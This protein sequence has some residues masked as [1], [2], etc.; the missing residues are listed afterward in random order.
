M[1]IH[2]CAV[3]GAKKSLLHIQ[4][5]IE[6]Y[7]ACDVKQHKLTDDP[8]AAELIVLVGDVA[9]LREARASRLLRQYPDKAMV[10]SE[11]DAVIP[12]GSGLYGS[13][14]KAR[15]FDLR[16]TRSFVYLSSY[17]TARNPRVELLPDTPKTL[18]FSFRGKRNCRVRSRLMNYDFRRDDVEVLDATNYNH[19]GAGRL[20]R[21]DAQREYVETVA[22]SHFA[23][24]P[25]GAG[26]GSIRLFEVMQM[27]VAPVLLADGYELPKGPNWS[28]FLLQVPER[29]YH[30]L[31]E[32]LTAH[33]DESR[34]RGR[35]ARAAWEQH[36]APGKAF[37]AMIDQL[38]AIR[39][40]RR[41]PQRLFMLLWP[42]IQLRA[43]AR[44]FVSKTLEKIK[45][46][47][48]KSAK[49]GAA[50]T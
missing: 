2:V 24:C 46:A 25:R 33:L 22:R 43:D 21:E 40:E 42:V 36:F 19:W 3:N 8:E 16:R 18:L 20:N 47:L 32:I 45:S 38:Q 14:G 31:P 34:E 7:K 28:S 29:E 26:F 1:L 37:N 12:L 44:L 5:V 6:V 9:S 23:L 50:A 4:D 48:R 11:I 15:F 35:L 17:G 41:M 10:Y 27:G 39:N 13:A 30:R 49:A